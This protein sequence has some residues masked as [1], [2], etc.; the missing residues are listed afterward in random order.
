M[1]A[2]QFCIWL[3]TSLIG[4]RA[5]IARYPNPPSHPGQESLIQE[6]KL[7]TLK[8]EGRKTLEEKVSNMRFFFFSKFK[9]YVSF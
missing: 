1:G 8:D 7:G 2:N 4:S 9:L 6:G 3:H 5:L